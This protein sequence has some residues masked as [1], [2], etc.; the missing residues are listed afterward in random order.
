MGRDGKKATE[1]S[2]APALKA[3]PIEG[4]L[5]VAALQR[6]LLTHYKWSVPMVQ[7]LVRTARRVESGKAV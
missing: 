4:T 7:D 2:E 1:P 6:T 5:S 3:R